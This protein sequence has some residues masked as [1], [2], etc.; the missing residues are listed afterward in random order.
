MFCLVGLSPRQ[1]YAENGNRVKGSGHYLED[2]L[3]K[4]NKSRTQIYAGKKHAAVERVSS[5]F[6]CCLRV[7]CDNI[8]ALGYTGGIPFD[9]LQPILLRATPA[10]LCNIESYNPYL[11]ED[12]DFIWKKH[13][14]RE[15]AG[16]EPDIDAGETYRD[17]YERKTEE[18]DKRL[19]DLAASISASSAMQGPVRMAKLAD[20]KA[21]REVL[22]K[23]VKYGTFS[24]VASREEVLQ[25]RRYLDAGMRDKAKVLHRVASPGD[26]GMSS[27]GDRK[28]VKPAKAPLMAKTLKMIKQCQGG[29]RY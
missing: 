27:R 6:E 16:A 5:L 17:L 13:C 9:I 8:D 25:S 26:I 11:I 7:L 22:R 24:N 23:Q 2:V 21:P 19:R 18:R 20:A 4:K 1:L 29:R 14:N 3:R 28:N 15:F 12:T 10:Q